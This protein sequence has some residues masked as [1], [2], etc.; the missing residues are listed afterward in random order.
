ML[1]KKS[2]TVIYT[3]GHIRSNH[4]SYKFISADMHRLHQFNLPGKQ[5]YYSA[6][7]GSMVTATSDTLFAGKPPRLACCLTISSLGAMYTQ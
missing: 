4:I 7:V 6:V 3:K 2:L 1:I 5:L